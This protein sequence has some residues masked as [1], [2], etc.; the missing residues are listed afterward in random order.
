MYVTP[1]DSH[2]F[3][4]MADATLIDWMDSNGVLHNSGHDHFVL[5]G[6]QASAMVHECE[7]RS[8]TMFVCSLNNKCRNGSSD[9]SSIRRLLVGIAD[10]FFADIVRI[11]FMVPIYALISLASYLF[12]VHLTFY[13]SVPSHLITLSIEPLHTSTV[14]P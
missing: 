4:L 13:C 2:Y 9:V 11:L 10:H 3:D 6:E 12:W 7:F 8:E 5:A 1:F 14:N